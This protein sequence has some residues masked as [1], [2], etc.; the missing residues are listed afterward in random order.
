MSIVER[1][2][3]WTPVS[4]QHTSVLIA[5]IKPSQ[6]SLADDFVRM[7][8]RD[9]LS[10]LIPKSHAP[11]PVHD[12]DA[13]RKVLENRLKQCRIVKEWQHGGY[14]GY[15]QQTEASSVKREF[16]GEAHS[17]SLYCVP[18]IRCCR[19]EKSTWG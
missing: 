16:T 2:I 17:G 14:A 18:L 15:R 11:L 5:V 9:L 12:V 6:T 7:V 4:T 10:T 1:R 13:D 8:A 3:D 19:F